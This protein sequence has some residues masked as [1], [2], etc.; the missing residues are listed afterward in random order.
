MSQ[1]DPGADGDA[2]TYHGYSV[3]DENQP[4][5]TGTPSRRGLVEPLARATVA[6]EVA[7]AEGFVDSRSRS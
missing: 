6:G 1:D 7:G 5:D 3:D 2:E 4:Q